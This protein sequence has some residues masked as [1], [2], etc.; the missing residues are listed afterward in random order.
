MVENLCFDNERILKVFNVLNSFLSN[1]N[2]KNFSVWK[3]EDESY[4]TSLDLKIQAKIIEIV[5]TYFPDHRI[6]YEEG[7]QR[8]S[9]KKS[10]FTWVI[11]PIDGTSNLINGK[12]EYGICIGLMLK[13]VFIAAYVYFPALEERYYAIKGM[14]VFKNFLR[15]RRIFP[16]PKQMTIVLCSKSF[17]NLKERF[18]LIGYQPVCYHCATYGMLQVLKGEVLL[19]HN[20][21]TNLY[22]VGPMS[23]ILKELCV[24]SYNEN[25]LPINYVPELKKIP[26]IVCTLHLELLDHFI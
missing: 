13:D 24:L 16:N 7:I 3:K 26:F 2:F 25:F 20:I 14:G 6:L 10:S 18:E 23:F 12:K 11:D 4:V 1:V 5:L 17:R 21:N 22:D 19:Y 8:H 9:M 15:L